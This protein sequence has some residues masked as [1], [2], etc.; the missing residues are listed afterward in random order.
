MSLPFLLS[1]LTVF[2]TSEIRACYQEKNRKISK[3]TQDREDINWYSVHVSLLLELELLQLG[4]SEGKKEPEDYLFQVLRGSK[5]CNTKHLTVQL[6][7]SSSAIHF[8]ENTTSQEQRR[9]MS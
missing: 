8:V 9:H 4:I 7:E 1:S 2:S 3:K 6:A 5:H